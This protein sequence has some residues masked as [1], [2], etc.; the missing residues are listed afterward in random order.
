MSQKTW[1]PLTWN[2]STFRGLWYTKQNLPV[3]A[4]S[5]PNGFVIGQGRQEMRDVSKFSGTL[6]HPVW[7]WCQEAA[8]LSFPRDSSAVKS[9]PEPFQMHSNLSVFHTLVSHLPYI[10][11]RPP[12]FTVSTIPPRTR[13]IGID[14][15]LNASIKNSRRVAG[16]T[17]KV[18]MSMKDYFISLM[19]NFWRA[20]ESSPHHL[21]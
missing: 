19:K 10:G 11:G 4:P 20:L 7:F 1:N 6:K 5:M 21:S 13:K 9:P 3:L 18:H 8:E 12:D 2:L 16:M 15:T 17:L 14:V